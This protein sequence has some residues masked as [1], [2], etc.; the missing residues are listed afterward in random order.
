[1]KKKKQT[2]KSLDM[3]TL[4]RQHPFELVQPIR[5]LCENTSSPETLDSFPDNI[6]EAKEMIEPILIGY[7]QG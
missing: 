7:I 4:K 5:P 6:S 3:T 1:M 2:L